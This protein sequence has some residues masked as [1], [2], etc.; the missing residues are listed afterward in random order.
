[1]NN[2]EISDQLDQIGFEASGS[3]DI[4][5][6]VATAVTDSSVAVATAQDTIYLFDKTGVEKYTTPE[7]GT[8]SDIAIRPDQTLYG[9][10]NGSVSRIDEFGSVGSNWQMNVSEIIILES[11]GDIVALRNDGRIIV[12]NS[13]DGRQRFEVVS[14]EFD[15]DVSQLFSL[16]SKFA[17]TNDQQVH[18]YDDTGANVFQSSFDSD[19]ISVGIL[20]E[21]VIVTTEEAILWLDTEGEVANRIP[22]GSARLV[23]SSGKIQIL[24]IQNGELISVGSIPG[25]YSS[26]GMIDYDLVHAQ[27]ES[28]CLV[29]NDSQALYFKLKESTPEFSLGSDWISPSEDTLEVAYTKPF[30]TKIMLEYKFLSSNNTLKNSLVPID[31]RDGEITLAL[32]GSLDDLVGESITV[33]LRMVPT[34]EVV[35][36]EKLSVNES[37][38]ESSKKDSQKNN[39]EKPVIEADPRIPGAS[40]SRNDYQTTTES[41]KPT[42]ELATELSLCR[43]E[44]GSAFLKFTLQNRSN[45]AIKDVSVVRRRPG[46]LLINGKKTQDHQLGTVVAGEKHTLTIESRFRRQLDIVVDVKTAEG[47]VQSN[48]TTLPSIYLSVSGSVIKSENALEFT[49]QNL[50]DVPLSDEVLIK[51]ASKKY[52][53]DIELN[54]GKTAIII[55]LDRKHIRHYLTSQSTASVDVRTSSFDSHATAEIEPPDATT[56]I[57]ITRDSVTLKS[58]IRNITSDPIMEKESDLLKKHLT[59]VSGSD[60]VG[61]LIIEEVKIKNQGDI[62][63]SNVQLNNEE[64][65]EIELEGI[66][67]DEVRKCTRAH[68]IGPQSETSLPKLWVESDDSS[69]SVNK[70]W[71]QS[72]STELAAYGQCIKKQFTYKILVTVWNFSDRNYTIADLYINEVGAEKTLDEE[73]QSGE[74]RQFS[75]TCNSNSINKDD[76]PDVFRLAVR[77]EDT[78]GNSKATWTV[79]EQMS[80]Y[81]LTVNVTNASVSPQDNRIGSSDRLVE[82]SLRLA[83][84]GDNPIEL[85]KITIRGTDLVSDV[86]ISEELLPEDTIETDAIMESID[87]NTITYK[88]Q[89]TAHYQH[90]GRSRKQTTELSSVVGRSTENVELENWRSKPILINPPEHISGD[91]ICNNLVRKL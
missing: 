35:S 40:D 87:D 90:N 11:T 84:D 81:P 20:A 23:G 24:G 7:A 64:G 62:R 18:I 91:W 3:V 71:V 9:V 29:L 80:R 55:P 10:F 57:N 89:V 43:I 83:N 69:S 28:P 30:K 25:D 56:E 38:P 49:I 59:P 31:G 61:Q 32:P 88:I 21:Y 51:F 22:V 73:V 1:M 77:Y 12:L 2:T 14:V 34:D 16:G 86:P 19:I 47:I 72:Q 15:P 33:F 39:I 74:R 41:E 52:R 54:P 27:S 53:L 60:T 78:D 6:P 58:P 45:E 46:D 65:K 17:S 4:D 63:A 36:R 44:N 70:T 76:I 37:K 75:V 5:Q 8:C 66:G 68:Y 13:T 50:L 79:I 42:S 82:L 26:F 85:E 67:R 48:S